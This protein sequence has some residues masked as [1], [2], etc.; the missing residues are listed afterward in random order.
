M[1]KRKFWALFKPT[2]EQAFSEDNIT[3]AFK[4]TKIQPLNKDIICN[5]ITRP[6]IPLQTQNDD[7]NRLKTPL[8]TKSIYHF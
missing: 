7:P 4:K 2:W 3:N 5:I 8:T 6:S 1:T